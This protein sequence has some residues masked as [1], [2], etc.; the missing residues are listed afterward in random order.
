MYICMF[1]LSICQNDVLNS[2]IE[3]VKEKQKKT[4]SDQFDS[5]KSVSNWNWLRYCKWQ[6]HFGYECKK[7]IPLYIIDIVF[8]CSMCTNIHKKIV[9]ISYNFSLIFHNGKGGK[10]NNV[11]LVYD[12]V[13]NHRFKWNDTNTVNEYL[14]IGWMWKKSEES[15]SI[16]ILFFVGY[17]LH[18]TARTMNETFS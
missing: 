12:F 7:A 8:I 18:H 6:T 3:W 11:C 13:I 2:R 10:T 9:W 16:F 17:F 4:E 1:I 15:D 14:R 5:R